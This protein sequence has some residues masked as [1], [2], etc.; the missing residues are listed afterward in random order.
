MKN[1]KVKK[2][3]LRATLLKNRDTHV[4]DFEIAWD[5][6]RGKAERNLQ[7]LLDKLRDAPRGAAVELYVGLEP[8]QNHVGDYT[9]AIE[10]LDWEVGEEVTLTE[11]EFQ[12][13]VQDDW[14]WKQQFSMTN[15]KYTGSASPST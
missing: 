10:M 5:A 4:A 9:R 7:R 13:F 2:E 6:F 1:V 11:Q 8:P 14:S 12:Q 3:Q 15:I